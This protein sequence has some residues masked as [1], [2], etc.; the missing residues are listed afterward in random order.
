MLGKTRK[1]KM[2]EWTRDQQNRSGDGEV[3]ETG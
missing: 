2:G 3:S 1:P